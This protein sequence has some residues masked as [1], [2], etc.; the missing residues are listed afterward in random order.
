MA[1]LHPRNVIQII[2]FILYL[3]VLTLSAAKLTPT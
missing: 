1:L 2:S 3:I